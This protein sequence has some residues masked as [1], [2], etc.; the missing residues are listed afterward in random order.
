MN[1][2]QSL[3]LQAHAVPVHGAPFGALNGYM[4]FEPEKLHGKQSSALFKVNVPESMA[5]GLPQAPSVLGLAWADARTPVAVFGFCL[6]RVYIAAAINL[7][8]P[9]TRARL[10][11]AT[12]SG[13]FTAVVEFNSTDPSKPAGNFDSALIAI[14]ADSFGEALKQ[15]EGLQAG[16]PR[17]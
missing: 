14:P 8:D 7:L 9:A 10:K 17:A 5:K 15:T 13:K 16:S 11:E 4:A 6:G 2:P 12:A 3:T 1:S